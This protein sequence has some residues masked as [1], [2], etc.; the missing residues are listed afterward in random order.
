[1]DKTRASRWRTWREILANLLLATFV[2]YLAYN[3][4]LDY[5]KTGR[6]SSLLFVAFE[7]IVVALSIIRRPPT[8]ISSKPVDWILA[9]T[10]TILPL[11][12]RPATTHSEPIWFA[13]Q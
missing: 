11:C 7:V 5:W 10:S 13:V 2:S 4:L 3:F 8:A 9:F 1:M 6:L 12:L